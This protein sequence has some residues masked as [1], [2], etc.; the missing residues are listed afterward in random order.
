MHIKTL[1]FRIVLV[2]LKLIEC[3][4][5]T[6]QDYLTAFLRSLQLLISWQNMAGFHF[7]KD[8]L[9]VAMDWAGGTIA[10]CAGSRHGSETKIEC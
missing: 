7:T 4:Q 2:P 5:D 1:A 6:C 3:D 9:V 10:G 8:R